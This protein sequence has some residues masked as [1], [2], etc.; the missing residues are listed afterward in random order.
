MIRRLN[1][2]EL[3]GFKTFATSTRLEFPGQITAIVGRKWIW[4][5]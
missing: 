5:V 2:L 1:S 4:E 3:Q